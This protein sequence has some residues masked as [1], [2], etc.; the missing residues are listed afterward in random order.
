MPDRSTAPPIRSRPR[1]ASE[2][3]VGL[4]EYALILALVAVLS[5]GGTLVLGGQITGVLNEAGTG[6]SGAS[7]NSGPVDPTPEPTPTPVPA[8]AYTK[9]KTCV[10]AGHTWVTKPKPAH[11]V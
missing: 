3:G 11:C 8:S 1:R 10:A 7:G 9:K 2:R 6:I 4:V 5:I